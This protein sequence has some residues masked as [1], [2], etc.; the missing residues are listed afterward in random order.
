VTRAN[1]SNAVEQRSKAAAQ[2]RNELTAF[3]T[4]ARTELEQTR[5]KQKR[6]L[7]KKVRRESAE[8]RRVCRTPEK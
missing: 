3:A 8:F 1:A 6:I 4:L 7:E 5:S 2:S